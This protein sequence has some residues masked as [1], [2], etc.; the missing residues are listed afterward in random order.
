ML[1]TTTSSC[2]CSPTLKQSHALRLLAPLTLS[3]IPRSGL[4][5]IWWRGSVSESALAIRIEY[6][7]SFAKKSRVSGLIESQCNK[8][9]QLTRQTG[10]LAFQFLALILSAIPP[11]Y[12]GGQLSLIVRRGAL[13]KV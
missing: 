6:R 7:G 1:G 11:P 12:S 10:S 9:L 13:F 4:H 8:E 5:I 3:T 2:S